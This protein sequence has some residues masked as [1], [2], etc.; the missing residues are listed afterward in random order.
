M[1]Q[2][3][4]GEGRPNWARQR[5]SNLSILPVPSLYSSSSWSQLYHTSMSLSI[6]CSPR[7]SC[8]I[9]TVWLYVKI[10]FSALFVCGAPPGWVSTTVMYQRPVSSGLG[11]LIRIPH[12]VSVAWT[13]QGDQFNPWIV[14]HLLFM[15]RYFT[16]MVILVSDWQDSLLVPRPSTPAMLHVVDWSSFWEPPA[17]GQRHV[18]S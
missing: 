6:S 11:L 14:V 4:V 13:Q 7:C 8:I 5:S 3:M 12:V 16:C 15:R 18:V 9:S 10:S 1:Y 2:V 17:S